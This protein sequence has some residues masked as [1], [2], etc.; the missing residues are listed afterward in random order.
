VSISA[1]FFET[2][3]RRSFERYTHG[4]ELFV[5]VVVVKVRLTSL[6]TSGWR[7]GGGGSGGTAPLVLTSASDHGGWP[8]H[9]TA[10]ARKVGTRSIFGS[11]RSTACM[12]VS[13]KIS[14]GNREVICWPSWSPYRPH[15]RY[16]S[17][18]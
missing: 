3:R 9:F 6:S 12:D 13:E 8:F 14:I 2:V 15:D 18:L 11:V 4:K 17:Y 16:M 5:V 7:L 10:G 1:R